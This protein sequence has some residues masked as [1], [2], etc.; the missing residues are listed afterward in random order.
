M[1]GSDNQREAV[2]VCCKFGKRL[3][4]TSCGWKIMTICVRHRKVKIFSRT[5]IKTILDPLPMVSSA[6][7]SSDLVS[8]WKSQNKGPI[9]VFGVPRSL[10]KSSENDSRL[11][12]K[13]SPMIS[14]SYLVPIGDT[15]IVNRLGLKFNIIQ[16]HVLKIR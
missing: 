3:V 8:R 9:T 4:A 6:I 15:V 11:T 2:T 16:V 5:L 13:K 1:M 10:W 12:K 7:E 14:L